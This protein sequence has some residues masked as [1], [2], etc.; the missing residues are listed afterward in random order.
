VTTPPSPVPS[1]KQKGTVA[2]LAHDIALAVLSQGEIRSAPVNYDDDG[3]DRIVYAPTRTKLA[4]FVQPKGAFTLQRGR[5]YEFRVPLWKVPPDPSNYFAA[6]FPMS[7]TAPWLADNFWLVPGPAL[8]E[9]SSR[10]K[11]LV[12]RVPAAPDPSNH[13]E[14]F[15]IPRAA[16]PAAYARAL[17]MHLR[18]RRQ[19]QNSGLSETAQAFVIESALVCHLTMG[20]GGALQGWTP[21]VD[22]QGFDSSVN[23]AGSPTVLF[24]QPKGA[25][26]RGPDG[27]IQAHVPAST[28]H[29]NPFAFLVILEYIP[30][31]LTM[32]PYSWF[33]PMAAIAD[34]VAKSKGTFVVKVSPS[35]R[36]TKDN[37]LPWRYP[38]AQL[39]AVVATALASLAKRDG[40]APLPSKRREILAAQK[41]MVGASAMRL[42]TDPATCVA[43]LR[44]AAMR[45]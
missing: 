18:P 35:P 29:P 42:R 14:R 36:S 22:R 3:I 10:D 5:V 33:I 8:L 44:R 13:W 43:A 30:S 15:R 41:A 12:I 1:A 20:S 2:E 28:F 38:T 45:P 9:R 26:S 37:F 16:L 24:L 7:A 21:F 31:A 39:P 25:L 40:R 19:A 23:F 4:L 17:G 11:A 34:R 32:G 6:L 27:L